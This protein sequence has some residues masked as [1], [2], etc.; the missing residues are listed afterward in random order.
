MPEKTIREEIEDVILLSLSETELVGKSLP[1]QLLTWFKE[2]VDVV[3]AIADKPFE[4]DRAEIEKEV[5][6]A[7]LEVW[8]EGVVPYDVP[9]VG[10]Y[11]ET[12]IEQQLRSLIAP[13]VAAAFARAAAREEGA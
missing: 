1:V 6:E 9:A 5:V 11:L 13:A 2:I 3:D 4:S 12:M 8:D 7:A 10:P